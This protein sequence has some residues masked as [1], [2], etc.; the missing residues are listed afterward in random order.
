MKIL[1]INT[2]ANTGSTGRIAEDIGKVLIANGHE[3]IVAFGRSGQSSKSQLIKIGSKRDVI[4]HGMKTMLFDK[5]GFGSKNATLKFIKKSILESP[6]AIGLHNLHGYYINIELL[7]NYLKES[8]VPVLWTLFDCWA[9]TGHCSY[10]DDIDCTK[11]QTKCYA[12]PKTCRYPSSYLLDASSSNFEKKKELFTSVQTLHLVVHSNWLKELVSK[13]F[14]GQT[15][16]SM[17]HSGID[18]EKFFPQQQTNDLVKK[19]NLEHKKIILGV[20]NIWILRKGLSDFFKLS[21]MIDDDVKII[22]VGLTAAQIKTLPK[23]IIG[24]ERTESIQELACLYSI[25]DVFVNPTYADNFPTTNIEALACGTPVITY[26]TVGS[27]EA[28][29]ELTG[30]VV[31][32]GNVTELHQAINKIINVGKKSYTQHCRERAEL[33]FDKNKQYLKY[34]ELYNQLTSGKSC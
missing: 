17:I 12:C 33:M 31:E 20:A 19:Y 7:F 27:P 28:V 34:M 23:N 22:L 3:S 13:S 2:S 32:K 26:N 1:Q 29:D 8:N 18:L 10:F 25:A 30:I 6:D 15:K 24:I 5:H 4:F 21:E 16:I 11:W 14:L 9:F